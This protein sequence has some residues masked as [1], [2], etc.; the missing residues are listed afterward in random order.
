MQKKRSQIDFENG[1]FF[2]VNFNYKEFDIG[3]YWNYYF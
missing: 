3:L 1:N 2:S